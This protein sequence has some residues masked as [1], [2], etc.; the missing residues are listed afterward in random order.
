MLGSVCRNNGCEGK[1]NT[2]FINIHA[3]SGSANEDPNRRRFKQVLKDSWMHSI[4]NDNII[5]A[6]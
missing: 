6:W 3:K 1:Q 5:F 4:F 2:R